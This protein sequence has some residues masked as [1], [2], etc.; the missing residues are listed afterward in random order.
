M[1]KPT[2]PEG[3]TNQDK[4]KCST[5]DIKQVIPKYIITLQILLKRSLVELEALSLYGETCLHSTISFLYNK[6]GI[7]FH[8]KN[9]PH[10]HRNGG[11]ANFTR[12][13]IYEEDREKTLALIK[14]YQ[15]SNQDNKG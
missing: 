4:N 7:R 13:S 1:K 3:K 15:A 14:P 2:S 8:R 6:K 12:Y 5:N 10:E 9:E 11:I